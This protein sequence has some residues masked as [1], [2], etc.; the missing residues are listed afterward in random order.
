MIKAAAVLS[1]QDIH[2]AFHNEPSPE[3]VTGAVTGLLN[4]I[5]KIFEDKF[6]D[7]P[8]HIPKVDIKLRRQILEKDEAHG[9]KHG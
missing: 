8:E 1:D 4:S 6:S 9:I 7:N 5:S 3:R 2:S